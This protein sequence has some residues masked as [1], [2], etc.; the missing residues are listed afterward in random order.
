MFYFPKMLYV[1]CT[2]PIPIK[3][4]LL[5]A[6]SVQLK[7]FI[8]QCKSVR[9]SHMHLIRH[10]KYGGLGMVDI[11]DY[12][13]ASLLAQSKNW[14]NYHPEA[15]WVGIEKHLKG[16]YDLALLILADRWKH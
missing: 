15:L 9:C 5:R 8:W 14:F 16:T 11:A 2:L 3:P 4:N 12:Y 13:L 7:K 6:L 10:R 1:F